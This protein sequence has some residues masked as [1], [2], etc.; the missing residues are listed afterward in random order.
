MEIEKATKNLA[1]HIKEGPVSHKLELNT[2]MK[3]TAEET[4]PIHA[5]PDAEE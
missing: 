3:E 1:N 4:N 5:T 2:V